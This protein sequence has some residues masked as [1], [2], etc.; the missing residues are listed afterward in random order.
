MA[1]FASL[2]DLPAAKES[3]RTKKPKPT[4]P[5]IPPKPGKPK[6][7]PNPPHHCTDGYKR[8][9]FY[10]FGIFMG[11]TCDRINKPVPTK[12]AEKEIIPYKKPIRMP[13]VLVND[14]SPMNMEHFGGLLDT[15]VEDYVNENIEDNP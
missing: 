9:K 5:P 10:Q 6:P 2:D 13:A 3:W 4:T 7:K 11:W 14:R 8:V 12:P 1:F 15:K